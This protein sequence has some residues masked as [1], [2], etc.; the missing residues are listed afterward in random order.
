MKQICI[1]LFF[2]VS[3]LLSP[4]QDKF[5]Y[6]ILS[7]D[8]YSVPKFHLTL[9]P[10][11][12]N[13][14][15][16]NFVVSGFMIQARGTIINR[17][18]LEYLYS[19]AYS[20]EFVSFN[21]LNSK[22]TANISIKH[23]KQISLEYEQRFSAFYNFEFGIGII[24]NTKTKKRRRVIQLANRDTDFSFSNTTSRILT[25]ERQRIIVR[26]GYY[27]YRNLINI[28]ESTD[29][30]YVLTE[31][32][33]RLYY[34]GLQFN[35]IDY[36]SLEDNYKNYS[37]S[38]IPGD[39]LS[40]ITANSIYAGVEIELVNNIAIILSKNLRRKANRRIS[41]IYG[42]VFFNS[43][44]TAQ[45]FEYFN[46]N[47]SATMYRD[48]VGTE[49]TSYTAKIGNYKNEININNFGFRVGFE[50]IGNTPTSFQ[51]SEIF[52]SKIYNLGYK[53]ELG[54]LPG[55]KNN[56]FGLWTIFISFNK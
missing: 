48:E 11:F 29:Y 34:D 54:L 24:I 40:N 10:V 21:A 30:Q 49:L 51:K 36:S 4:A 50:R 9:S 37:Y 22:K 23:P 47:P 42:D 35:N 3:N 18:V 33:D 38:K 1:T 52:F 43:K 6:K 26:A 55:V 8:P 20:S 44:I 27:E 15:Q 5:R 12:A 13:I 14:S 45:S 31:K 39:W 41:R 19:R 53:L 17:L 7:D 28:S 46:S 2:V 25:S 16:Q 32:G 56:L